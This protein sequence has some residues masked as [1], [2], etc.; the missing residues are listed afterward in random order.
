MTDNQ[1]VSTVKQATVTITVGGQSLTWSIEP[2][3]ADTIA[4]LLTS[5]IGRPD[6]AS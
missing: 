4:A 2:Q 3:R 5:A 1:P 6:G